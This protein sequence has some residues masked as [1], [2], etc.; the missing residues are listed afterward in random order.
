MSK[1]LS[2]E[3]LQNKIKILK[4]KNKRIVLCH[5][6]FDIIHPGHIYHFNSAKKFGDILI[7]SVTNDENV[8]KGY[9]RPAFNLSHRKKTLSGLSVVDYVCESNSRDAVEILKKIKPDIYC[10]GPD[11]KNF[12]EDLTNKIYDEVKVLKSYGGKFKTTDDPIFSSSKLLNTFYRN[13]SDQDKYLYK[14]NKKFKKKEIINILDKFKKY[15]VLVIGESILDE[16]TFCD[17]LGKSGKEPVLTM[18]SLHTEKF[19]GGSLAICRHLSTFC[20]KVTLLSYLGEKREEEKFIKSRL[21]KNIHPFF[22]AKNKSPTIIKRRFIENINKIK[23]LGVYSLNDA[24]LDK[25]NENKFYKS[26]KGQIKK[27]D[28]II[29]SDYGHGL[30]NKRIAKLITS[31]KKFFTL[32]AQINSSNLGHH[33]LDKFSKMNALI[34]NANELRHE[35]RDNISPISELAIKLKNKSKASNIL[36]TKGKDGA[37]LI[38]KNKIFECPGFANNVVDKIGAGDAM[39]AITSLCFK[40]KISQNL[41][42]YLGSLAGAHSVQSISNSEP[43]KK[44]NI[45]KIITHQLVD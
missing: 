3:E 14:V 33:T 37:I 45:Q 7:I 28:L 20:K 41:T 6:V 43:V 40:A 24:P 44:S 17:A 5:G 12:K 16:Y 30:I 21:E 13:N 10:K 11:Y 38:H 2:T 9:N 32:N 19:L 22:L 39:L 36:V 15:K 25:I 35:F 1:I 23:T 18:K 27:H 4:K 29:I 42:L 26:I 31:S 8:K 34:I